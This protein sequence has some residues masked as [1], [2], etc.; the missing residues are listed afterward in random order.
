MILI[1][2]NIDLEIKVAQLEQGVQSEEQLRFDRRLAC[3]KAEI[4]LYINQNYVTISIRDN[5]VN[6]KKDKIRDTQFGGASH[7]INTALPRASPQKD[8]KTREEDPTPT[9]RKSPKDKE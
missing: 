5:T 1:A 7:V 6:I 4:K 3:S 2:S 9:K 8:P